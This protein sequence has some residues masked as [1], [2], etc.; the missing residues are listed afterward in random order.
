MK[1]REIKKIGLFIGYNT[2]LLC[3]I[4]LL[5]SIFIFKS[6]NL[7]FT[8]SIIL[9][10]TFLSLLGFKV[11]NKS[12]KSIIGVINISLTTILI[13]FNLLVNLNLI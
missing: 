3:V 6:F 12:Y 9:I 7:V 11:R 10:I 5:Y 8:S 2:L 13:L 1:N 4:Y